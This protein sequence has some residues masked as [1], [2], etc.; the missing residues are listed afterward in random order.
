MCIILGIYCLYPFQ[1]HN[2][3][4]WSIQQSLVNTLRLRQNGR[5]FPDDIFKCILLNENN[6]ISIKIWLNFVP[7]VP[8]NGLA[9]TRRQAIVWTS[10][11]FLVTHICV[12]R[13]Q[14]IQAHFIKNPHNGQP[15]ACSWGLWFNCNIYLELSQL[16]FHL[17]KVQYVVHWAHAWW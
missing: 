12:T 9:P 10:D 17:C 2:G 3:V 4:G 1:P 5:Q 7:K 16:K 14:W 13:P 15:K 6:W 8:I 11:V